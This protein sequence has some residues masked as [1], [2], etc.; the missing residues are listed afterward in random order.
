MR[1]YFAAARK[2]PSPPGRTRLLARSGSTRR[3]TAGTAGSD[4]KGVPREALSATATW[5]RSSRSRAARRSK[6]GGWR[7]RL[8]VLLRSS[9][10]DPND[11]RRV[12]RNAVGVLLY[13]AD[14]RRDR[15]RNGA[16][17]RRTGGG[18]SDIPTGCDV[19]LDALATRVLFDDAKRAIGVEYLKGARL[20]RAHGQPAD[21]AGRGAA[22]V[23]RRREVILAGG[24]F[25]T[26]QLLMLSGIGPRATLAR[27]A[28]RC[29]S[30][31]RGRPQSAGPL[32]GRRR[33]PDGSP[34][35]LRCDGASSAAAIRTAGNGRAR[36][37]HVHLER[38]GARRRQAIGSR[39]GRCPICSAWRCWRRSRAIF[40]AI[41]GA[42]AE[43]AQLTDLG[44]P[45]GAH[46]QSRRRRSR[47]APPIRGAAAGRF[48]LFR[49][50]ATTRTAPTSGRRRRH[51]FCA[52]LTA[53]L[54]RRGSDRR[55]GG[56]RRRR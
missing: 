3:G 25:N 56:A 34:P 27:W 44:D 16:R 1:H 39:R 33:Q 9:A 43:Q 41:P 22:M 46:P 45:Q 29:G 38:R 52:E 40:P 19:E 35:G 8:R 10:A 31:A 50:K 14:D 36:A 47:C 48:P 6:R 12:A 4:R 26:P 54:L 24:A 11:W 5:C 18:A 53:P 20:Y 2:L 21:R 51:P 28:S 37:G 30:T 7:Q 55:G 23:L 15:H 49:P 32:R 13:A 42:I 17:E